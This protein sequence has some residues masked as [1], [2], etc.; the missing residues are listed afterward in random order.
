MNGNG[1]LDG[2]GIGEAAFWLGNSSFTPAV[3]R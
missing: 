2:I 3:T 1:V